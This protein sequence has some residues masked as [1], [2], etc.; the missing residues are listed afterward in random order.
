VYSEI[1]ASP[2]VVTTGYRPDKPPLPF[3]L[4]VASCARDRQVVDR[5]PALR[6]VHAYLQPG[7]WQML[8]VDQPAAGLWRSQ[9]EVPIDIELPAG[10][11]E[12]LA[13]SLQVDCGAGST[14]Q[15]SV[16]IQP[17]VGI[18]SPSEIQ[19]GLLRPG[20]RR[21]RRVQ[22][23]AADR[24][25]FVVTSAICDDQRC[26][27]TVDATNPA[28]RHWLEVEVVLPDDS[29]LNA[30]VLCQTDHPEAPQVML[31]VAATGAGAD[32]PPTSN[33]VPER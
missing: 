22:L 2:R 4:Q 3:K 7:E 24:V 17:H 11:R 10:Y 5:V 26:L 13:T 14:T 6:G 31:R 12:Q 30:E 9:W 20:E 33:T 1:T 21:R 32:V 27:V 15:V 23:A 19:F 16:L 29:P 28:Q 8:G 18:R 25:D